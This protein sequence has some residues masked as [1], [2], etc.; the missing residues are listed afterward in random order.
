MIYERYL[1]AYA[2][3]FQ[4]I[5]R[6]MWNYE[7]GC[8]LI[9]LEAMY[10]ATDDEFYYDV[11]KSFADKYIEEDGSI[12]KYVAEE[13][14]LDYIPAGRILY[15]LYDRTHDARYRIAIEHLEEQMRRQPRTA[16]GSYWHKGIYPNQVWLDGLYM[17]LP[18][19][20]TYAM[21]YGGDGVADDVMLQFRNARKY[22]FDEEKR[23]YYHAWNETRDIF[24]ADP[25]TGR[26]QNF[27][28]RA[29]GWFLM[30]M[31]DI[32][33][34]L[35]ADRTDLLEELADLWKEAIDGILEYQDPDSGLFYQL[36]ALPDEPGN[37]LETSGSL[38][39]A[40]SL[41]KGGRLGVLSGERYRTIGETILAGIELYQFSIHHG[42]ISLNG[43]CKGAGLGPAG[44]LRRNGTVAY[45]L[46]EDVVSDEQKG[47]GVCMMVYAEYLL[48]RQSNAQPTRFPHVEM[49]NQK[50][51]PI[52]PGEDGFEEFQRQRAAQE[53]KERAS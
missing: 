4:T 47:V 27:W 34:L 26:S 37:Y 10:H 33:E 14:N 48:A 43:M 36:P 35:P 13:Y 9:G 41:L 21:T 3:Q 12:R 6:N 2:T 18:Y 30:A 16:C 25:K 44:N 15:L 45:Y 50:Y 32:Y 17:G 1:R 24:W 49:F 5:D 51:D 20:L 31:A 29:I 8:V 23:L 7:D 28:L 11:L 22:L 39:V 19:H 52:M 38:M 40:Y 46:S 42:R 53:Q